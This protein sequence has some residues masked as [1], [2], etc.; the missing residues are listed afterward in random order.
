MGFYVP[1]QQARDIE[2]LYPRLLPCS[3]HVSWYFTS[4]GIPR[5]TSH[6]IS[7]LMVLNALCKSRFP[8]EIFEF[9]MHVT[10]HGHACKNEVIVSCT[11]NM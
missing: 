10:T 7:R 3:Q 6:G 8:Q 9:H 5:L 11:V 2:Y 4:R 1:S